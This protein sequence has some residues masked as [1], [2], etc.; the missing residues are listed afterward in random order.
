MLNTPNTTEQ[1]QGTE[2]VTP[3]S[4]IVFVTFQ[5]LL[6]ILLSIG[7]TRTL[8]NHF[9]NVVMTTTPSMNKTGNP[10]FGKVR[11]HSSRNYRFLIDYKK[12]VEKRTE[13]ESGVA[14]DYKV[15]KA[16]GKHHISPAVLM[17]DK[18][19]TIHYLMLEFFP[20]VKA[21]VTYS[22]EKETID[23]AMFKDYLTKVS[24]CKKQP[25]ENKVMCITPM[26]QNIHSISL[27]G[28][29]YVVEGT[30]TPIE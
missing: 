2:S 14:I 18:T 22:F 8:N 3:V 30:S 17:D 25:Q 11:K 1:V 19:N 29:K 4:N 27:D 24:E 20:E 5:E 10:Y 16:K 26:V 12:R 15:E 21:S 7:V 28:T 6:N 9:V 23:Y 13:Q